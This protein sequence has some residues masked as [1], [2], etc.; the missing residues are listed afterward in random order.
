M[1]LP[2]CRRLKELLAIGE[3]LPT[4]NS[5]R[6]YVEA[7]GLI[8]Y[9]PNFPDVFRRA[10]DFVNK[11]LRGIK[12]ADLTVEQPVKFGRSMGWQK[13]RSK[14]FGAHS[15]CDARRRQ[16]RRARSGLAAFVMSRT[17]SVIPNTN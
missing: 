11:I 2:L 5:I 6:G 8:S 15:R 4:M 1:S 14:L 9:G 7:G 16:L 13:P 12:P 3:K 10:G 17:C